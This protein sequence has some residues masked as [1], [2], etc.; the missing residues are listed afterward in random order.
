MK[1]SVGEIH[2]LEREV[3][4]VRVQKGEVEESYRRKV[5]EQQEL[6][7]TLLLQFEDL[8][9]VNKFVMVESA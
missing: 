4:E 2:R 6:Y 7:N 1:K 9:D 8:K 3:E 5:N